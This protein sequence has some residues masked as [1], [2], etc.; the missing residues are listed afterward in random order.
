MP[1]IF[2]NYLTLFGMH[3]LTSPEV[4][5]GRIEKGLVNVLC[6]PIDC[7]LTWRPKWRSISFYWF[8][9]NIFLICSPEKWMQNWWLRTLLWPG[10]GLGWECWAFSLDLG[11]L[12]G[13]YRLSGWSPYTHTHTHAR[14]QEV[15]EAGDAGAERFLKTQLNSSFVWHVKQMSSVLCKKKKRRDK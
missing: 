7:N 12:G 5:S 13:K 3:S 2:C 6:L 1:N 15:D 14:G 4:E 10:L 11:N 9:C 8:S